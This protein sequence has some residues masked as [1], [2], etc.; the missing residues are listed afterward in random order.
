MTVFTAAEARSLTATDP[1][2]LSTEGL[3]YIATQCVDAL[4]NDIRHAANTGSSEH[5]SGLLHPGGISIRE[6]A[7]VLHKVCATLQKHGYRA[8]YCLPRWG[9]D[10]SWDADVAHSS[11]DDMIARLTQKVEFLNTMVQHGPGFF[12]QN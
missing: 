6:Q 3:D 9:V 2:I 8:E 10:I 7:L 5:S 11:K 4:W 1:P 12:T